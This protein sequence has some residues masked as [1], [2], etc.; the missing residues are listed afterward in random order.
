[1]VYLKYSIVNFL[2]DEM[3]WWQTFISVV[4]GVPRQREKKKRPAYSFSFVVLLILAVLSVFWT[5]YVWSW[6]LG[7]FSVFNLLKNCIWILL[8]NCYFFAVD[9]WSWSFG[10]GLLIVSVIYLKLLLSS[11]VFDTCGFWSHSPMIFSSFSSML[12]I[13]IHLVSFFLESFS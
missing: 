13:W 8:E 5:G 2:F 12:V 7:M 10:R 1:M 6:F 4:L 3:I 9:P 11:I